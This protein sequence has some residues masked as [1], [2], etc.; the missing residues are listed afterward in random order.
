MC[1][2]FKKIKNLVLNNLVV[3]S[4]LIAS[5]LLITNNIY[6]QAKNIGG[7]RDSHGCLTG[8]GYSWCEIG[9]SCVRPWELAACLADNLQDRFTDFMNTN[10]LDT[11]GNPNRAIAATMLCD[12]NNSFW[13]NV[14]VDTIQVCFPNNTDADLIYGAVD[15]D[16]PAV[17]TYDDLDFMPSGSER[18]TW[19]VTF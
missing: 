7:K 10:A 2:N 17:V 14:S 12:P 8:A 3:I 4:T 6:T 9:N 11:D 19:G 16:S 15:V 18:R 5:N 1:R 13:N